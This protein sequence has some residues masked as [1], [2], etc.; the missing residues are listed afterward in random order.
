MEKY[1]EEFLKHVEEIKQKFHPVQIPAI[2]VLY[3][4]YTM[5]QTTIKDEKTTNKKTKK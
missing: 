1:P 5:E 4:L 3:M 2:D